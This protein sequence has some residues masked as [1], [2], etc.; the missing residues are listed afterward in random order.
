MPRNARLTK[1]SLMSRTFRRGNA[2]A[3]LLAGAAWIPHAVLAN[4]RPEG[5][6]GDACLTGTM[7]DTGALDL[8]VVAGLLLFAGAMGGLALRARTLTSSGLLTTGAIIA[9]TGTAALTI[10]VT[11][12][13][14]HRL[15]RPRVVGARV[16]GFPR[17]RRRVL[18]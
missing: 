12:A 10:G 13:T 3:A 8:L 1:S 14:I 16:P 2:V 18:S 5:C 15:R 9:A 6:V 11:G 17:H 7:R 4:T